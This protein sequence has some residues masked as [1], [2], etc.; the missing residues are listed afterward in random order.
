MCWSRS[1]ESHPIAFLVA[2]TNRMKFEDLVEARLKVAVE[3]LQ[4]AVR[5]GAPG[6]ATD[7]VGAA[8]HRQQRVRDC[9]TDAD[10]A[11]GADPHSLLCALTRAAVGHGSEADP[12][13]ILIVAVFRYP[14]ESIGIADTAAAI[15]SEAE[16]DGIAK[17]GLDGGFVLE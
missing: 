11:V 13:T 15:E 3:G 9:G 6:A 7:F 12:G 2:V 16:I 17:A 5:E 4:P 10:E 14:D 8:V 1:F